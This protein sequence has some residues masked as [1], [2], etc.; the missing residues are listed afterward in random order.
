MS[1]ADEQ[2]YE[3]EIDITGDLACPSSWSG[4]ARSMV[5]KKS[6]CGKRNS[7]SGGR[8]LGPNILRM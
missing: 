1:A 8:S 2:H 7:G 3:G 5:K 6:P 4:N